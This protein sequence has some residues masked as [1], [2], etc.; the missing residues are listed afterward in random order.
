[1]STSVKTITPI[2]FTNA[3]RL[4]ERQDAL[5]SDLYLRYPGGKHRAK[6]Q[7]LANFPDPSTW[8]TYC[9]PMVG[10]G[11]VFLAAKQAWPD[12]TYVIGDI[13]QPL[14]QFWSTL[15][16]AQATEEM[17]CKLEQL[18]RDL[19]T[20]EA[21]RKLFKELRSSKW[22]SLLGQPYPLADWQMFFLNR[23]SFSGSTEAGGFSSSAAVDRFTV[24]SINRLRQTCHIVQGAMVY[25]GDWQQTVLK[26][27]AGK[28][29][30]TLLMLDPPYYTAKRLYGKSGELHSFDHERLGF[31]RGWSGLFV[32]TYDDCDWVRQAY[33]GFDILDLKITYGMDAAKKQAVELLIT[34]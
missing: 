6:K 20:L 12:K 26:T 5:M 22:Q 10:G 7:I 15:T 4:A 29:S 16:D 23:C 31:L 34:N 2:Q 1:M 3:Q 27:A 18:W 17:A 8:D 32:L 13:Y 14:A 19:P 33:Q 21:R 24:S 9:E 30:R 25:C 28:P 11:S